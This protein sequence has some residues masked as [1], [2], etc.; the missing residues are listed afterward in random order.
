MAKERY[1]RP[2]DTLDDDETVVIRG[3]ELDRL[4]LRDDVLRNHAIYG[5]FGISV[6]ALRDA[7]VDELAQQTPM[8]RF[9]T[10]T[11]ITVG[12]LR[13]A[14]LALEPTGRNPRHFDVVFDDLD[15]GVER[16]CGCEHRTIV[17]PYYEI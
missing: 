14:G 12:A 8:V 15:L 16:L 17:N 3:G 7:T 5:V 10:L 4:L 2:G 13:A 11:L 1:R 9:E 6:F